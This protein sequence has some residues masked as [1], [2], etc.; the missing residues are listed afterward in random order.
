MSS[1]KNKWLKEFK[2]RRL[3]GAERFK[4][5]ETLALRFGDQ[6]GGVV[7][8]AYLVEDGITQICFTEIDGTTKIPFRVFPSDD[9]T[10][11]VTPESLPTEF[12]VYYGDEK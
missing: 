2:F 12:Y 6:D 9:G 11:Y 4:K 10:F 5:G 1:V 7:D 3:F 8:K